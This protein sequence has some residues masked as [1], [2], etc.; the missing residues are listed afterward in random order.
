[1]AGPPSVEPGTEL[2]IGLSPDLDINTYVK[3]SVWFIS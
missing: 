2:G 3:V 1:M